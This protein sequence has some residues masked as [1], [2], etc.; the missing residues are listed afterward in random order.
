[1]SGRSREALEHAL[2]A[3][4]V[5]CRV[6][7]WD[8]LAVAIPARGDRRLEDPELRRRA[9]AIA[10]EHGFSHLALELVEE[11]DGGSV[12]RAALPRP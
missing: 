4:G 8:A 9:V 3:L 7:A 11:E 2:H 6:E 1:V 12:D 5:S 10:R